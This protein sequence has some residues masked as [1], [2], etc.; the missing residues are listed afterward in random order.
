MARQSKLKIQALA[1]LSTEVQVMRDGAVH[2]IQSEMLVPGDLILVLPGGTMP[3]D[4]VLVN[5]EAVMNEAAITGEPMPATKIT[6]EASAKC[7]RKVNMLY[8]ATQV[9]E[10]TGPSE[11]VALAVIQGIGGATTKASLIRLVLFPEDTLK[12]YNADLA[13]IYTFLFVMAFITG[14]AILV[15]PHPLTAVNSVHYLPIIVRLLW[16]WTDGYHHP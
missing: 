4:C 1:K 12:E 14:V 11:G 15:I 7:A 3:C 9:L 2:K 6:I 16:T 13:K 5:G 8:S 10:S